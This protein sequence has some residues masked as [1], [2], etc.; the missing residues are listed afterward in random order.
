MYATIDFV[1]CKARFPQ[2]L[3]TT[4]PGETVLMNKIMADQGYMC[5]R[6]YML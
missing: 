6:D 1:A 2:T 4:R 3:N 5:G